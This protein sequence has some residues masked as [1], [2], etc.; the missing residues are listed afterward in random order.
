MGRTD[1][2][3]KAGTRPG[4]TANGG[5]PTTDGLIAAD[6]PGVTTTDRP[7]VTTTDRPGVTFG[8]KPPPPA[9]CPLPCAPR[10]MELTRI[11]RIATKRTISER[12]IRSTPSQHHHTAAFVES[13]R[14]S[15]FLNCRRGPRSASA[16]ARGLNYDRA[17]F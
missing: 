10:V 5:R 3:P 4:A 8:T 7:G 11:S 13:R 15:G 1:P 17:Y 12:F 16:I 6:R 14:I 9:K 2:A